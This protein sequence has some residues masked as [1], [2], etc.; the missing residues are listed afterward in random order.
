MELKKETKTGYEKIHQLKKES[1]CK[2]NDLLVMAPQNDPF[3]V[4]SKAQMEQAEWFARLWEKCRFEFGVH[5]RRIHYVLVSELEIEKANGKPYENTIEDWEYLNAS[6]RYA[7]YLDLVDPRAFVDKRNPEP[8]IF[9][10]YQRT[11]SE[12]DWQTLTYTWNGWELPKINTNLTDN[13]NWVMPGYVVGG[14][15]Y[16]EYFQPYHIEIWEEKSTMDDILV[17]LCEKYN[18]NLVTGIGF[19]SITRVLDLLERA[20][21]EKPIIILYISDFDPAGVQMPIQISRQIEFW[22]DKNALNLDIKLKPI[23][24]TKEQILEYKLPRVPIKE[25]DRRKANFEETFGEGAVELDA[26]EALHQGEFAKIIKENILKYRDDGLEE[27]F[28]EAEKRAEESL[29]D[30][31]E[32]IRKK[33]KG[34]LDGIKTETKEIIEKYQNELK[35]IDKNMRD[36]LAPNKDRLKSLWQDIKNEIEQI[37]VI[38][39]TVPAPEVTDMTDIYL[40]DSQR[41]YMGQLEVYK[42]HKSNGKAETNEDVNE[43]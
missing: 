9:R 21:S 20:D 43:S 27:E 31:W 3:Y 37:H 32:P 22:L 39:P 40:F 28:A 23:I 35:K 36:E 6:G 7:R 5:L 42:Q 41:D 10:P 25:S 33:F 12:P 14:Y 29:K 4:G 18:V 2:I 8:R 15:E 19:L 30:E 1:G 13:I 38:L 34:K 24:L 26:L 17:P 16:S 11:I